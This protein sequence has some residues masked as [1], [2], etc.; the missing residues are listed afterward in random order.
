M[1]RIDRNK[2]GV[3]RERATFADWLATKQEESL[4]MA[5]AMEL[6]LKGPV[7]EPASASASEVSMV[8][9]SARTV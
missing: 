7:S 8:K 4:S 9:P 1:S 5:E 6:C 3:A 2:E